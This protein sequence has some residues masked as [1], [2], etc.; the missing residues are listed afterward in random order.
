MAYLAWRSDGSSAWS[1]S[2]CA[3]VLT[4]VL[5]NAGRLHLA[6]PFDPYPFSLLSVVLSMV[7][8]LLTSFPGKLLKD[9]A[10]FGLQY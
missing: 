9:A 8:V 5:L 6:K 3:G 10:V 7:A 1:I 4:W 2:F